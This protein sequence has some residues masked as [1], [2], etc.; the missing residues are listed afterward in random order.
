[1]TI[2]SNF[3]YIYFLGMNFEDLTVEFYVLNMHIK[4]FEIKYYI[5]FNQ[6]T[7]FLYIILDHKNLKF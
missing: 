4:F 6:L 5:L 2:S 3:P 1:M 7:Y